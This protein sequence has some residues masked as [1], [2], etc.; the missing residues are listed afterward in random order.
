MNGPGGGPIHSAPLEEA[1]ARR[2]SSGIAEET[3]DVAAVLVL[4]STVLP[5]LHVRMHPR[6]QHFFKLRQF[7]KRTIGR[8]WKGPGSARVSA[9]NRYG[10]LD[11]LFLSTLV[12]FAQRPSTTLKLNHFL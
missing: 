11:F 10:S 8:L 7:R 1:A 2:N 3:A 5:N 12:Q 9:L 6:N 4:L